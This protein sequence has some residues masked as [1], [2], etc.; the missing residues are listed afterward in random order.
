MSIFLKLVYGIKNIFRHVKVLTLEHFS[1]DIIYF[2]YKN[3]FGEMFG[4]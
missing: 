2:I 4:L 1:I 3:L